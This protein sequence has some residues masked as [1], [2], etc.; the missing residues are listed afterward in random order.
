M[1]ERQETGPYL[2]ISTA[3]Q[4]TGHGLITIQAKNIGGQD[5]A[6]QHL[7]RLTLTDS[8]YT[9]VQAINDVSGGAGTNVIKEHTADADVDWISSTTG[10]A[11]ID[12]HV[13]N[14]PTTVYFLASSFGRA[15]RSGAFVIT[16]P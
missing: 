2:T 3:D 8:T 5:L 4:S 13:T 14:D 7:C 15:H 9:A 11:V 10:A 6:Q 12:L 16:G 1:L